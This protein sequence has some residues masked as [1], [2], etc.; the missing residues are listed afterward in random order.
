MSSLGIAL[1]FGGSSLS[2]PS[3]SSP[4]SCRQS[5]SCGKLLQTWGWS[6]GKDPKPHSATNPFRLRSFTSI[7]SG[8]VVHS[9]PGMLLLVPCAFQP[10][11]D[12]IILG[13]LFQGAW[14]RLCALCGRR[15]QQQQQ[16]Q[17]EEG[18]PGLPRLH[19]RKSRALSSG[20]PPS[21]HDCCLTVCLLCDWPMLSAPP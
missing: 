6:L 18:P 7:Y 9:L 16:Q 13:N 21:L 5:T 14:P 15:Q 1:S 19:T 2:L 20:K 3:S 11:W 17:Q 12:A 10:L 4:P 8:V